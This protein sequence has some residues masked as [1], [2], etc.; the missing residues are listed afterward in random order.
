M[1]E[2][3]SAMFL[4]SL[5]EVDITDYPC[6][7]IRNMSSIKT[8]SRVDALLR[9]LLPASKVVHAKQSADKEKAKVATELR[10]KREAM[11]KQKKEQE[12]LTSRRM[13]YNL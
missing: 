3:T 8:G 2:I 1:K 11:K 13:G 6:F 10:N 5:D 7:V 9:V 4:K 12:A